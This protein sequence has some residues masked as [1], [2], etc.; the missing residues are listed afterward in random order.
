[1]ISEELMIKRGLAADELLETEAFTVAVN[2]LYNQYLAE[3][4]QSNP[5]DKEARE[6]GYFQLRALTAITV[7]LKSWSVRK[8]Q[9]LSP[10][11]E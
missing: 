11:E 4:T 5:E 6:I 10:T 7:E 2:E 9:L 1:M 3:I 8:D